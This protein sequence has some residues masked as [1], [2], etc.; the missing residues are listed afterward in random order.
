MAGS[1]SIVVLAVLNPSLNRNEPAA[2]D[3][4]RAGFR[5]TVESDHW[6]PRDPFPLLAVGLPL[7]VD[8]NREAAERNVVL[9][10]A[11]FRRR[12]HVSHDRDLI[13]STHTCYLL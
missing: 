9:S 2:I 11:Q 5:Q 1:F 12:T 13:D 8:R 7:L 3:V 6:K 10:V 4:V